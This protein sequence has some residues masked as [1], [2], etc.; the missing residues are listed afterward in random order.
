[1][2]S[3]KNK[4]QNCQDLLDSVQSM[5][6]TRYDNDVTDRIGLLHAK[7]EIELSWP[8]GWGKVYDE[9]EIGQ[10]HD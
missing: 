1:M 4:I 8:I 2:W 3:L 5:T 7:N 10:R 9:V 6:K